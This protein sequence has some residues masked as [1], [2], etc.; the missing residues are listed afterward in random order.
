MGKNDGSGGLVEPPLGDFVKASASDF[1]KSH[2]F[3]VVAGSDD[4]PYSLIQIN[5]MNSPD[6]TACDA[7]GTRH[8][9]TSHKDRCPVCCPDQMREDDPDGYER[10][11]WEDNVLLFPTATK[12]M[13]RV[14]GSVGCKERLGGLLKYY[15]REA[16]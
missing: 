13:N 10:E 5:P 8:A 6:T 4:I 15:H 2:V 7:C 14:D 3:S 11:D 12:A 9:F 16:A 1:K